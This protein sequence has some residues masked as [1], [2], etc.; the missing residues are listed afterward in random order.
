MMCVM[1]LGWLSCLSGFSF[2][3]WLM[4]FGFLFCR[5][6]LVVIGFGVMVF[7]WMLCLCI[8][9]VSICVR[10]LIVV[11]LVMYML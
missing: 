2:V 5:N 9:C 4:S 7:M 1:L 11:L 10:F 8:F 6:N 3:S